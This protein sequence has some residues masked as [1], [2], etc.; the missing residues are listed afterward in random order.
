MMKVDSAKVQALM[1]KRGV[2]VLELAKLA[3]IPAKTISA[4][5]RRDAKVY[6]STL[7]RLAKALQ[8]E[9]LSLVKAVA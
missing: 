1:L 4:L 5:H 9:P 2:G 6:I 7:S 3:K 8:V